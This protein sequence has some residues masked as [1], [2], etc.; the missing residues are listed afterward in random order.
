MRRVL[1]VQSAIP[2]SCPVNPGTQGKTPSRCKTT[3]MLDQERMLRVV[4]IVGFRRYWLLLV[5]TK[6]Y[7]LY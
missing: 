6:D 2:V 7:V 5:D 4:T 1:D 3:V